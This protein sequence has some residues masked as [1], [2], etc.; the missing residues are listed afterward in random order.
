MPPKVKNTREEIIKAAVEIIRSNGEAALNVRSVA[1]ALGCSTQPVFSNF[2]TMD[3]LKG[4]V[5]KKAQLIYSAFAEEHIN[6][7]QFSNYKAQGMAYI[8]FAKNESHLF[9]LLYL[10]NTDNSL[11][12]KLEKIAS[13]TLTLSE[14]EARLFNLEMWA[15]VHGMAVMTA[16]ADFPLHEAVISRIFDDAFEGIK[17]RFNLR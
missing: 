4:E 14:D 17:T 16:N 15:F 5:I 8:T 9:K 11:N 12:N 2:K 7:E 1:E 13:K 6:S 10:N 3:E